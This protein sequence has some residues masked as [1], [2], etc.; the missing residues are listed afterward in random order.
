MQYV[1][2]SFI[3]SLA[4]SFFATPFVKRIAFRWGAI[5]QPNKRK[6]HQEIMPRLGGL[7]IYLGFFLPFLFFVPKSNLTWAILSAATLIVL[8]GALD[9]RYQLSPKLKLLGQLIATFIV[10][11]SGLKVEFINLP[12]NLFADGTL[13]FGWFSIPLSILWIVGITNAVN[14]IDGLDGLAGGVSAIATAV[15]L[16]MAVIIGNYVVIAMSAILL[17]ATL[18]F[19]VFNFHPAK[20]FMG[21]TGALFLGFI[22]ASMS[23]YGF[24]YVTIFAFI[25][26]ILILAVPIS[27]TVFAIIRR[28]VHNRPISEADKNHLHHRLLQLGFSHRTTVLIIYGISLLFGLAAIFFSQATLWQA[29]L[30]LAI[31]LLLLE[32]LVE[33][34][35]LVSKNYKPLLNAWKKFKILIISLT[36]SK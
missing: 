31:I 25:M 21:D 17:G 2:L 3:L 11:F 7:A 14:L 30:M 33:T 28:V 36:N 8:T 23:I 5:D 13:E 24:K 6:V 26:P 4:I 35:G 12:F 15:I 1:I 22:L 34:I 29:V 9:D 20:I 18:G 16:V 10:V 19:L 27:D 32:I